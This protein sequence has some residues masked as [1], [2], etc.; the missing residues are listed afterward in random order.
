M[1][2]LLILR[3]AMLKVVMLKLVMLKA[4]VKRFSNWERSFIILIQDESCLESETAERSGVTA[5]L[6]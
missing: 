3:I 2:K 6:L 4:V 5:V 1:L